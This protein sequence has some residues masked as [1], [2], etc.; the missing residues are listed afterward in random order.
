MDRSDVVIVGGGVVG[1]ATAYVVAKEGIK[2]TLV[3]EDS[4]GCAASGFA[5]GL[6]N[7][8]SR[9]GTPTPLKELAREGFRMHTKLATELKEETGVDYKV[10]PVDSL[11]LA[12]TK[13][14]AESLEERHH[15]FEEVEGFSSHW[16]T[17]SEIRS[18]EPRVSEKVEK[19]LY[20]KGTWLLESYDYTRALSQAAQRH[21]TS[22]RRSKVQGLKRSSGGLKEVQL[23]DGDAIK[24]DKVVLAMGPWA[25]AAEEWLGLPIPIT[26][27]KGQI[28]RLALPGPPLDLILR[29]SGN[30]AGS[31]PD[32][33]VWI[34][35]T[36]E[37]VG[38]DNQI[39]EDAKA[40]IL[41]GVAKILPTVRQ[42][43]LVRQTACLR[44]ASSDGLP[45][46]GQVPSWEGVYL[47]T[48]A[49]RQGILLSPSMARVNFDLITKGRTDFPIDVFSLARFAP[50]PGR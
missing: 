12:F 29:H 13:D 31:K 41:E 47:A 43:H 2:V 19:C 8:V 30:Y 26:P 1:C 7:P 15:Y 14:E 24:A 42:G 48:G 4:V 35:T 49:R 32:G 45:I 38:F 36:E 22:I 39:T 18:L 21:G 17:I 16:L 11:Y 37:K 28:L 25:G 34:G 5:M 3:E 23:S 33:L 27:L 44:P 9:A 20:V 10:H 50:T 40:H 6:L 46:L